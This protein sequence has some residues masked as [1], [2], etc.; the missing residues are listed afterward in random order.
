MEAAVFFISPEAVLGNVNNIRFRLSSNPSWQ[1]PESE[2]RGRNIQYIQ[3]FAFMT[4]EH[5]NL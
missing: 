2:N 4:I 3:G 1:T 5:F